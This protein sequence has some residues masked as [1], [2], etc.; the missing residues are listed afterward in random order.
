[1]QLQANVYVFI[2]FIF[3]SV[4]VDEFVWNSAGREDAQIGEEQGE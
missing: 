2:I 1:M 3:S 4:Q